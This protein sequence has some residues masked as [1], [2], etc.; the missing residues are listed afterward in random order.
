MEIAHT[1]IPALTRQVFFNPIILF[2]RNF[3][4]YIIDYYWVI[5]Y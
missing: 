3:H 5:V 4:M 2:L 1:H